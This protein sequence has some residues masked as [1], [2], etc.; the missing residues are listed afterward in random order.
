MPRVP[1]PPAPTN[2]TAAAGNGQVSLT[3][4][5]AAGADNYTVYRRVRGVASAPIATNVRTTA[6]VDTT[7]TNGVRY[8]YHVRSF[9]GSRAGRLSQRAVATPVGPPPSAAPA[10]LA[11]TAGNRRVVLTWQAVP[12]ATGYRV[13]RST[14]GTFPATPLASPSGTSYTDTAVTNG[15]LYQYTVA[16]FNA[17]GNGPAAELVTATP[18][19]PPAAP[20]DVAATAGAAQVSVSWSPS[21]GATSYKVYRG[22]T[23]GG[24]GSAAVATGLPAGPFV[25]GGRTNG[26]TYF[27]VVTAVNTYGESARS[28]EVSGTPSAP[29]P[30]TDLATLAAFR[31]LRQATWGPKPGD[32]ERL[33]AMGTAAFLIEQTA[34]APSVYPD[35]LLDKSVEWS[36]EHFMKLAMEGPDQLRQRMAWALHKI[37]VVSAVELDCAPAIL[38]YYRLLMNDALGN[39][40]TVMRDMTLNPAMGRYLNMLNN[41]SQSVSG[42]PPNENYAR[43]VM[44][45]FTLGLSQLNADGSVRTNGA[46]QPLPTYTE[47]DVKALSRILTGWTFGDG[48]PA[49]PTDFGYENFLVPM[50]PIAAY[51]DRGE[52]TFLGVT[53]PA[54]QD[55]ETELNRALDVIFAHANMGPFVAKQL[56]QQ[57]VTSNPSPAYVAAVAAAF[58]DN[59]TGVRGDLSA[60]IRA[61]LT[62]PEGSATGPNS[63][64]LS[65]PVLFV[66][67]QLRALDAATPDTPFMSDKTAEMGQ[68]VFYPPSVFSYFSPGF[69]VR[70]TGTPALLGPEFQHLTTVT[71]LLRANFVSSLLGGYFGSAVTVDFDPFTSRAA[72]AAALVDYTSGVLLGGRL[73]AAERTE[74]V[75]AVSATPATNRLERAH[76][77]LYLMLVLAQ[78]QVDR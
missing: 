51:H 48:N 57:F 68:K 14:T 27:Y 59:G 29:P 31:F 35:A 22:T 74:I 12:T 15:T 25:D 41:V 54:N 45:L 2:V 56:I 5:A 37:W 53:F 24:Q 10:A 1:P 47:Q 16:A 21:P 23:A 63:G 3:W 46:G 44:Q 72:D 61:V 17:G 50:E 67:S 39:Y 55:A 60:V 32:V 43:E 64:K 75:A 19:A 11:A 18:M 36:Q 69:R 52:K 8:V 77:A 6:Y 13:F 78:N 49:P 58:A 73:S 20:T 34:A 66:L 70:D 62:H 38:G 26:V 71:A 42:V 4:V 7:V 28:S 76:T 33:K 9:T 40:R 65:E 30:P